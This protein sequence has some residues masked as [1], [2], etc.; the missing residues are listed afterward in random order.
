MY[1]A[2]QI[3]EYRLGTS[4]TTFHSTMQGFNQRNAMLGADPGL[5]EV[6]K[7]G[8]RDPGSLDPKEQDQ[9]V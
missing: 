4:S 9:V 3:R 6:L 5:A 1:L 7:R 8:G 2:I